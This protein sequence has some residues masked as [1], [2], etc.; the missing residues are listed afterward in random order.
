MHFGVKLHPYP[1]RREVDSPAI[2]M[3]LTRTQ[4]LVGISAVGAMDHGE[5]EKREGRFAKE[6]EPSLVPLRANHRKSQEATR[7]EAGY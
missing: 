2:G 6:V 4:A 1:F 3:K 5:G 7:Y